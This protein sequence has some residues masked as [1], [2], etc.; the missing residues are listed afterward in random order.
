MGPKLR[1]PA[2]TCRLMLQEYSAFHSIAA[3]VAFAIGVLLTL[4]GVFV[5]ALFGAGRTPQDD[6]IELEDANKLPAPY[7][8]ASNQGL[9]MVSCGIYMH[10]FG[11]LGKGGGHVSTVFGYCDKRML[12][13]DWRCCK[14]GT[15]AM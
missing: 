3:A 15:Q 1:Y 7:S 13:K 9:F 14:R 11:F 8:D 6:V 10:I 12:E 4:A 2:I 5:V